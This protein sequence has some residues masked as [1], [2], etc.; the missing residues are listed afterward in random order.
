MNLESNAWETLKNQYL[1][2]VE[3]NLSLV[4]HPHMAEVLEDVQSHL[5]QR[6]AALEPNERT[7]KNMESII[8]EM[9]PAAEYAELLT[10]NGVPSNQK[11]QHKNLWWS[12]LIAVVIIVIAIIFM[13]MVSVVDKKQSID[14]AIAKN[15]FNI[16]PQ[17]DGELY[18]VVVSILNQGKVIS[19]EFPVN[20]YHGNPEQVEPKIHHAGPIE[21][22]D[23]WREST[24]PFALKEG[25]NEIFV[26]LDPY[27]KVKESDETNNSASLRVIFNEGQ[28]VETD[29]KIV[30]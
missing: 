29:T 25:V 12:G 21:P 26:V 15:G 4:K 3:K 24:V 7:C 14:L 9:G 6:L 10:S 18:F 27:D 8:S 16:Q 17:P 28:I 19:P 30:N 23:V 11:S 2:K 13:L 20:F 22:G 5:D 1:K